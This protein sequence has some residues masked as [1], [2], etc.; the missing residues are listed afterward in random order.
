MEYL[1]MVWLGLFIIFILIELLTLK[2][3]ALWFAG[4]AFFSFVLALFGYTFLLQ[5]PAFLIVS[6]VLLMSRSCLRRF[7]DKESTEVTEDIKN[8]EI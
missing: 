6:V 1:Y 4:G 7:L 3:I 5:I 8:E 2:V